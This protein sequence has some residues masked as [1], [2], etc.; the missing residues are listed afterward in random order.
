MPI[1]FIHGVNTRQGPAYQA[2]AKFK[3]DS[4]KT[5][6]SNLKIGAKSFGSDPLVSLP[7]WGDLATSFTWDMASLPGESFEVL[8]GEVEPAAADLAR[9][10][11]EALGPD[12]ATEPILT[13]ALKDMDAAVELVA[14]TILERATLEPDARAAA[15]LAIQAVAARNPQPTIPATIRRDEDFLL[16]LDSQ[17]QLTVFE[18]LGTWP[19][20]GVGRFFQRAG[21]LFAG[22]VL[23]GLGDF[24]STQFLRRSRRPLNATLGRFFGDVFVYLDRRGGSASPG[25][26]PL[27]LLNDIEVARQAAP[28]EPL[29]VVGHSLGGVISFDLLQSFRPDLEVD[30]FVSVGS[31]VAH[32]E[33]LKLYR[34]SDP[35]IGPQGRAP[36]PANVARWINVYDEV[37][38]FAYAAERVF[39]RVDRDLPYDTKTYVIKAHGAYLDQSR[40]YRWLRAHLQTLR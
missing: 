38:I 22:S 18:R 13:L 17:A 1:V 24:A 36:V 15:A 8:G 29:V 30:V 11:R 37:D 16:W 5:C 32:F 39:D 31:Q 9:Q 21:Q 34:G 20:F 12:V 28:N 3:T 7:Y 26:I 35:A 40:F 4:L 23:D 33:E 6:F 14:A 25:P 2:G 19:R 10:L 27:R